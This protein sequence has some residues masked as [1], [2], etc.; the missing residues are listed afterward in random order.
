M[1]E[2]FH[3]HFFRV[4]YI[5]SVVQYEYMVESVDVVVVILV[6]N[7]RD[8]TTSNPLGDVQ[9]FQQNGNIYPNKKKMN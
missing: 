3:Q 1:L 8:V 9:N 6:Y 5:C 2:I 7:F 4:L